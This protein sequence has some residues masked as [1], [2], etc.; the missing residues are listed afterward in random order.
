MSDTT[1]FE[2]EV[3]E[4]VR[5]EQMERLWK[6]YGPWLIGGAVLGLAGAA[7]YM[8]LQQAQATRLATAS[9]A[10]Y[11]AVDVAEES[12]GPEALSALR[13]LRDAPG[14][15]AALARMRE[16]AILADSANIEGAVNVYTELA[17][18]RSQDRLVRD[19]AFLKSA[20]LLADREEPEVFRDRVVPR[21]DADSPWTPFLQELVA[22]SYLEQGADAQALGFYR[23]IAMNPD[24]AQ[25]LKTRAERM[26]AFLEAS[27]NDAS[28]T[29]A[30]A[31]QEAAGADAAEASP[32]EDAAEAD[33]PT[34]AEAGTDGTDTDGTGTT[35][36]EEG[37]SE[38]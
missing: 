33:E 18:D 27:Q 2:R 23:D 19:L 38:E 9:N 22:L 10:Y 35:A 14:G 32:A 26:L 13:A 12:Q 11:A 1:T 30:Q 31:P 17:E 6:T 16:A 34:G 5:R 4:E 28:S 36:T 24:A 7:I 29:P 21:I 15:F 8:Y 20:Y 25:G 3:E 37:G